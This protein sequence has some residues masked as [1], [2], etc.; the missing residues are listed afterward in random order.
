MLN[1][2]FLRS[3][4][5]Q[6]LYAAKINDSSNVDVHCKKL[7]D[8]CYSLNDLQVYLFAALLE[9][10]KIA[11]EKIEE[12]KQKMLPTES[13][14]NPNLKFVEN[15]FFKILI[16]NDDL[17][18]RINALKINFFE[19]RDVLKS[20]FNKFI[21]SASYKNYMLSIKESIAQE[22]LIVVQLF[23]NY[24]IANEQFFDLIC[25]YNL[26]WESDYDLIAQLSLKKLKE[27]ED[28]LIL[29]DLDDLDKNFIES[30]IRNTIINDEE[31]TKMIHLRVKNWDLD[32]VALMDTIIIK[33][34]ISELIYCPEIPV[35]VTLNEYV[36]LSKEFST[37]KS[38]LFVNG[39]LDKLMVDLKAKGKI[40]K[41]E[42]DINE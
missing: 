30:L 27:C 6:E 25:E 4:V 19:Q 28:K 17:K 37:Q 8:S 16:E 15:D 13:D 31:F 39:L 21:L 23:K 2:H 22:R 1:R 20:I 34:G 24:L 35:N 5:L 9:M 7:I 10:H 29:D 42:E 3:K 18:K 38:K 40:K 41:I 11:Q 12:S 33:M 32:R 14:L 26:S 36:E